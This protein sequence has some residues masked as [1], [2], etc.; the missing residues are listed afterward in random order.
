[1]DEKRFD[2]IAKI[3]AASP[4][5]RGS[6]NLLAG[7]GLGGLATLLGFPAREVGDA[8]KQK[9]PQ[10]KRKGKRKPQRKRE[11][12]RQRER[13]RKRKHKQEQDQGPTPP[14]PVTTTTVAPTTTTAAPTT[15]SAPPPPSTTTTT[16]APTTTTTE[17]PTTTTAPPAGRTLYPELQTR[18]AFDLRFDQV[19][20]DDVP[21]YVL[22]FSNAIWNAGEGRL[23]LEGDPHPQ[24]DGAKKIYQNLYDAPIGGTR[25]QRLVVTSDIIYHPSH[26][27]YHFQ[28]FASYLL[29]KQ[30]ASGGYQ[31]TTKKGTKTSFCIYD[32]VRL[33]GTNPA[34][35]TGCG[36]ELTGLTPGW[37]DVYY[38]D[39]PDQWIVLGV[40]PLADGE[41]AIESTADPRGLIDEGGGNRERNN[42]AVT[43]FTVSGGQISNVRSDAP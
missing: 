7:V 35:Y 33:E 20:I 8:G 2:T 18:A 14:P 39:L 10:S 19:I 15:T 42:T 43:Y 41:Y 32:F 17:A 27:H 25:T 40:Q 9:R 38:W 5:R 23:E 3:L 21:Q 28:D 37:G 1:M 26:E 29:L 6:L 24:A 34:Q 30:D 31:P 36:F 11:Q 12:Q 22:R 13:Q 4:T 16:A